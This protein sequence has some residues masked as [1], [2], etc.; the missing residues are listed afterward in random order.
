MAETRDPLDVL[1][2][3]L[4]IEAAQLSKSTTPM[5]KA[6]GIWLTRVAKEVSEALLV[7]RAR[8]RQQAYAEAIR[9]AAKIVD[10]PTYGPNLTRLKRLASDIRALAPSAIPQRERLTG[11]KVW[12]VVREHT[13]LGLRKYLLDGRTAWDA[14]ARELEGDR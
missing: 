12:S 7:D 1:L 2:A 4:K 11:E 13:P 14:I 3:N 8:I 6:G 9:D 5:G 10:T